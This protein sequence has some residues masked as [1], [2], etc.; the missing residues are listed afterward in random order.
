[1]YAPANES[2]IPVIFC[3]DKLFF[4]Q[5][6][7]DL[8]SSAIEIE[9]VVVSSFVVDRQVTVRTSSY[10]PKWSVHQA[11]HDMGSDPLDIPWI[12]P[13]VVFSVNIG[14]FLEHPAFRGLSLSDM[15]DYQETI[16]TSYPIAPYEG[17]LVPVRIPMLIVEYVKTDPFVLRGPSLHL[18]HLAMSMKTAIG[19]RRTFHIDGP[20]VIG[21][22]IDRGKVTM[23]VNYVSSFNQMEGP[24]VC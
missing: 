1:M 8:R 17:L 14:H 3:L 21:L 12:F 11:T 6:W 23:V 16:T 20:P 19:L 2:P 5:I 15:Q 10:L 18:A 9:Y 22:L 13:D 4:E 24:A 7:N